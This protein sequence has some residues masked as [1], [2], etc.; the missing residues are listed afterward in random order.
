MRHC[1]D[2][3]NSL[4][5]QRHR[6]KPLHDAKT[7]GDNGPLSVERSAI[8]NLYAYINTW[9]DVPFVVQTGHHPSAQRKITQNLLLLRDSK[10]SPEQ[11]QVMKFI[12]SILALVSY[13]LAA[14]IAQGT[15]D[16]YGT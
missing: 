11:T 12:L 3:D 7:Q 4:S 10:T 15:Y 1:V 2:R 13:G 5:G 14:P 9:K 6:G 16:D 8:H